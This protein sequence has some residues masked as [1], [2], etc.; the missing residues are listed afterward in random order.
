LTRR[1]LQPSAIVASSEWRN[2]T[3]DQ[4]CRPA[5]F[6][7]PLTTD[8]VS[9]AIR[10][11]AE[12]N[13]T[14]RVAGS[15]HSFTDAVATDGLLL[16]LDRMGRV[17]DID[18][19]AGLVRVQAG[20]TLNALNQALAASGVALPNLGDVDVQT[21][22]GATATGTHGTGHRLAN[23]SGGVHALQLVLAD[24]SVIEINGDENP[25]ALRAARVSI[26]SLGV[27]TEVVLKIV[28]GFTLHGKDERRP[29]E[30]VLGRL[31]EI[32]DSNDHFEF[33]SFPHSPLVHARTNN[34]VD[35]VPRPRSRA[36][37]WANDVLL[38]NHLFGAACWIG[39]RFPS[40]IPAINRTVSRLGGKSSRV[41]RSDRVFTTPR[42]VRFTE[43]EYALPRAHASEAVRAVHQVVKDGG[44]AVPFPMEVRF[45][46]PDDAYLSPAYGRETC[47]IAVHMFQGM[48]WEPFFRAVEEIM[49][50]LDGRPHWGKRHF[51]TA[52]T[53]RPRYPEWDRFAA[54]RAGLDPNGRFT[55]D[56]VRRV[57]GP[58][59]PG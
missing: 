57:L 29:L 56:Y 16:L 19:V 28:E 55:N 20:I 40:W 49:D 52:E 31:D 41:D 25:D 14:V 39:R 18:P 48:S 34:R 58:S 32:V 6:E 27:V 26:G 42:H 50:G 15:G 5:A 11:A 13:W 2:W 17:L 36:G 44:F 46:A 21:V 7:R 22:A 23:L 3:G 59:S 53:L 54:V 4:S 24:G 12:H 51:Q 1:S 38:T 8:D 30:E 47:H 35:E 9:G 45:V 37:A 43:M 10:R 33:L